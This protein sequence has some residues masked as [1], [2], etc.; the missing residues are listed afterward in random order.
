MSQS[1]LGSS[2]NPYR[3]LSTSHMKL[4]IGSTDFASI[5]PPVAL[6]GNF[7]RCSSNS[8]EDTLVSVSDA[9]EGR[10]GW[11]YPWNATPTSV[12]KTSRFLPLSV[13]FAASRTFSSM[14]QHAMQGSVFT[15]AKER[16]SL[17]GLK[18]VRFCFANCVDSQVT[19]AAVYASV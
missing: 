1:C 4:A 19:T 11:T 12:K 3:M 5:K 10:R 6:T 2:S 9:R 18:S 8:L 16:S 15:R 7:L 14:S 13:A 17:R